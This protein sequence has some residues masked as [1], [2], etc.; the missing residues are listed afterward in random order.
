MGPFAR[1]FLGGDALLIM[2][3]GGISLA[4]S[5]LSVALVRIPKAG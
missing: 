4:L 5:A 1:T 2:V 3:C